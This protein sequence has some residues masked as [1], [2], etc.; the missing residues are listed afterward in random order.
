M[1]NKKFLLV[2]LLSFVSEGLLANKIDAEFV[3]RFGVPE[4]NV[5]KTKFDDK[6][7]YSAC[8][9][10]VHTSKVRELEIWQKNIVF[11]LQEVAEINGRRDA[12]T[13]FKSTSKEFEQFKN[14]N[15]KWQYLSML[16]DASIAANMSKECHIY[17]TIQRTNELKQLSQFE[18]F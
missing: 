5:C 13:L 18:F 4:V 12:I 16:P 8:L 15:C 9:D 14:K 11:K 17:M 6:V 3:D 7:N 10:T 2:Y 1:L